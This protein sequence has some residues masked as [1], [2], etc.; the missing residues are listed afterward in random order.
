[1]LIAV[2]FDGTIVE[3][4]YPAIGK[5]KIFAFQTLKALQKQGHL[6]V[7]WTIRSGK[8]LDEAVEYCRKN[9]VEFY[10]I[11]RTY[12]E[13]VIDETMSRKVNADVFIDDRNVGGF[14]GWGEIWQQLNKDADQ[15]QKDHYRNEYNKA[16]RKTL[17]GFFRYLFCGDE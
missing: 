3:H 17:C 11:N 7:L 15:A 2:D 6:L 16:K 10:A 9:G 1:M 13:E 12:P 8:L 14:L 4:K 5:E